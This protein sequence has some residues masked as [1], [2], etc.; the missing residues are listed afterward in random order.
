MDKADALNRN[1]RT[2]SGAAKAPATP[3]QEEATTQPGQTGEAA[4]P[5]VRG[6]PP[7][8]GRSTGII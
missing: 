7:G 6:A 8:D 4:K 1:N 3:A 5:K 2:G